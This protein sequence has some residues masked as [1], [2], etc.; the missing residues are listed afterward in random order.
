[1]NRRRNHPRT[2]RFTLF[3]TLASVLIAALGGVLFACYKNRQVRIAREI[4]Q[5]EE[6]I[7][8][9]EDDVRTVQMGMDQMLNRYIMRDRLRELGSTMV[10]IP[11]TAIEVV[12][13]SRPQ[14]SRT[15]ASARP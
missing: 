11:E 9:H 3:V 15:V 13:P 12:D 1:V 14:P 5:V 10:A 7:A 8:E 4:E 6:R 2:S